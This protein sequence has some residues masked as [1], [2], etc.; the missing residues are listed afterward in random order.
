MLTELELLTALTADMRNITILVPTHP[1]AGLQ[2]IYI[3]YGHIYCLCV[4][5]QKRMSLAG[6]RS[7]LGL[8]LPLFPMSKGPVPTGAA[9]PTLPGRSREGGTRRW[10][11]GGGPF[12]AEFPHWLCH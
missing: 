6:G 7:P 2:N 4:V 9:E 12:M 1:S 10:T 3:N 11:Q 5:G 8:S